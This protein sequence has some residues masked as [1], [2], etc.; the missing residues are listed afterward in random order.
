MNLKLR[1]ILQTPP[2][3]V[4]FGLQKGSGNDYQTEQIQR[5]TVGDLY[6]NLAIEVKGDPQKDELPGFKGPYVQGPAGGKFLYID[7]GTYAGRVDAWSRRLKIPLSGITWKM[8][9]EMDS[10]S[11]NILETCVPGTA[12][13]GSPT[14]ATVKPFAGW[15]VAKL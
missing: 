5:S 6:F 2:P 12:K 15:H 8:I 10:D 9:D 4:H 11:E 3:N 13:D 7:I 1:I 14:C